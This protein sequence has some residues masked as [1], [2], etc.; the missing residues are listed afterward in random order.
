MVILDTESYLLRSTNDDQQA[1]QLFKELMHGILHPVPTKRFTA[2]QAI[3]FIKKIKNIPHSDP[4]KKNVDP[5][6][7]TDIFM[8]FGKKKIDSEL[9]YLMSF[10]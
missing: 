4:F 5:K 3:M 6:N 8:Q 2:A 10:F 1:V 7:V 9:K